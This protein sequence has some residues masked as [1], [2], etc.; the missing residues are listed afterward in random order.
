MHDIEYKYIFQKMENCHV[1][2]G[3]CKR[4]LAGAN[5][6]FDGEMPMNESLRLIAH[7][8]IKQ[9]INMNNECD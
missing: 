2:R 6:S 1:F 9:Q 5:I 4:C 7:A 8:K 3:I